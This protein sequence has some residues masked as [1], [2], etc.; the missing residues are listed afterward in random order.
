LSGPATGGIVAACIVAGIVIISFVGG[1]IYRRRVRKQE[2]VELKNRY[3]DR[4][5]FS[6]NL[7]YPS[8]CE[9]GSRDEV[10][11]ARLQDNSDAAIKKHDVKKVPIAHIKPN[12][13]E[14]G[15]RFD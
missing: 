13:P 3:S 10:P 5:P 4:T 12:S 11:S 9:N 8:Y 14:H 7:R 6:A 15:F 2:D 1:L